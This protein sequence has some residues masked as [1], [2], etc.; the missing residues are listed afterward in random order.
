MIVT[1]SQIKA[2]IGATPAP[3]EVNKRGTSG[4]FGIIN[5]ESQR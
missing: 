4:F 1:F 5:E 2:L 3:G